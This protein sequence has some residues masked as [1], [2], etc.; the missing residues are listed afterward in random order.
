MKYA[1]KLFGVFQRLHGPTEFSGT[2]IG[3]S[4]VKRIITRHGGRIWAEGKVG[5]GAIFS[6][7]L[8]LQDVAAAAV[9]GCPPAATAGSGPGASPETPVPA[10]TV[11]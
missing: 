2:G 8:P 5:Q 10:M 4:I 6:F 3:L 11:G 9:S 7:A 1:N